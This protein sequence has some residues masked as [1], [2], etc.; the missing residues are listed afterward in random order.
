MSFHTFLFTFYIKAGFRFLIIQ[1]CWSI[2]H[3]NVMHPR[4]NRY[5]FAT[6]TTKLFTTQ[7]AFDI[8]LWNARRN[9]RLKKWTPWNIRKHCFKIVLD[10][11]ILVAI[12]NWCHD[13]VHFLYPQV[14]CQSTGRYM[15]KMFNIQGFPTIKLF[16]YGRYVGDY[17]GD[18][19]KSK[20]TLCSWNVQCINVRL[21]WICW[22]P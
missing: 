19:D 16:Q 2:K 11:R 9:L 12:V 1:I 10:K 5:R 20:S 6:D 15:C 4:I 8:N 13:D 21:M 7:N 18:R 3:S 17:I 22:T 14:D